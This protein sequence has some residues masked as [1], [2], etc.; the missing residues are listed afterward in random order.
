MK[1]I[2]FTFILSMFLLT[3]AVYA[4]TVKA[5]A[6]SNFSTL[7][8]SRN[9]KA[10]I[11]ENKKLS[12]KIKIKAGVVLS[13]EVISIEHAKKFKKD[14]KFKFLVKQISFGKD[15]R[16]IKDSKII[17]TVVGYSPI[18]PKPLIFCAAKTAASFFVIG[19]S[20]GISFVQGITEAEEGDRFK[21]GVLR[22]YNDSPFS[23]LKVGDE[24]DIRRGDFL[25]LNIRK[26][27]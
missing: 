14:A 26:I 16:K 12:R 17:V 9:F 23:Y 5:V 11:I 15:K 21:S 8:P 2:L 24:L 25:I 1:K 20:Q 10:Q 18:N 27:D 7:Y 22:V 6:L 4:K 13:G 3:S 19:A